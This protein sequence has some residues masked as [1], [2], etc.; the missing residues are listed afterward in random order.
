MT[1]VTIG[2]PVF[3]EGRFVAL[4]LESLLA[5]EFRDFELLVF[6]NASTD[7]T[8]EICRSFAARDGRIRYVRA[9]T[10]RG[11]FENFRAPLELART[12]Y[13]AWAAGHD[14]WAPTFLSRCIEVLESDG[15]IGLCYP[16]TQWIDAE[17]RP[18]RR[19]SDGLQTTMLTAVPRFNT[20]MWRVINCTAVYGVFRTEALRSAKLRSV[21]GGDL[22]LLTE[23]SAYCRFAEIP[24][25]LFQRRVVTQE[26]F[27]VT[28][29]RRYRIIH[30][31]A[32]RGGVR[33]P[34][35]EFVAAHLAM[36]AGLRVGLA[37][38]AV[39]LASSAL[40]LPVRYHRW[41]LDDLVEAA[42]PRLRGL[43]GAAL[44]LQ[45]SARRT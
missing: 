10:N 7:E 19:S 36:T 12:R 2:M 39:L 37:T 22:I 35:W 1:S 4:A 15:R 30:P 16:H 9:D 13:F 26:P 11:A 5:Q 27:D 17:G 21:F 32:G 3:N 33:L 20:I 40:A 34:Y 25:M 14:L 8:G 28:K 38:K 23:L 42:P 31:E 24:E 41:L 6:D 44:R 45:T 29:E 43:L 18:L